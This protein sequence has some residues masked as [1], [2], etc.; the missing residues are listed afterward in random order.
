MNSEIIIEPQGGLANRMRVIASG[1]WLGDITDQKIK[2]IWNCNRDLN[3]VFEEL[4]ETLENIELINKK[5]KYFFFRSDKYRNTFKR[6]IIHFLNF[7]FAKGYVIFE[8]ADIIKNFQNGKYFLNLREIDKILYFRIC[9]EFGEND[10]KLKQFIPKAEIQQKI[11]IISG[12]FNQKTIGI[13]I[14]RKDHKLAIIQSPIALFIKRIKSDIEKDDEVNYFLSTDDL[15]TENQLK[16][17][18]GERIMSLKKNF[19]RN[20]TQGIKDAVVDMYCLSRTTKIYG[21]FWSSFS[22]VAAKINGINLEVIKIQ[23]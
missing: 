19:S 14:R 5:R 20:S 9:Q 22:E 17:L 1:L 23:E 8:D 13:H 2:L 4:F 6:L 21:S 10:I 16:L 15:Q 3:A 12:Q 11:N 18:F 7:I